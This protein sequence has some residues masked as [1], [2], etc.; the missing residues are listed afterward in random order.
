MQ[1]GLEVED[2][3]QKQEFRKMVA[4]QQACK[5]WSSKHTEKGEG[6]WATVA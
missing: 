3:A 5:H 2:K 6:R 4:A 1:Q